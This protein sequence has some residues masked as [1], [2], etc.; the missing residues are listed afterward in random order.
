MT[1]RGLLNLL[2]NS[3]LFVSEEHL[4]R[5]LPTRQLRVLAVTWNT[6]EAMKIP[7]HLSQFLL[8]PHAHDLYVISLQESVIDR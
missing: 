7:H 6:G 3:K 8:Y 4:A 5:Y 1:Q 2:K